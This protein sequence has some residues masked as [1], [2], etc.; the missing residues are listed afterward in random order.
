M[1]FCGR[2]NFRQ[3]IKNKT[4]KVPERT[5]FFSMGL[6]IIVFKTDYTT[7]QITIHHTG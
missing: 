3:K 5:K 7:I 4:A 2:S 6:E 1:H